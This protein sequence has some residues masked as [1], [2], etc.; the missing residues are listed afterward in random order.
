MGRLTYVCTTCEEHFTRRYSATRHNLTIHNNRVEIVS[1]LE[2]LVGRSSGRYRADHPF[3]Y[4]RRSDKRIHRYGD[5]TTVADSMGDT[6]WPGGLQQGQ[7]QYHQQSLEEQEK[8]R[9]QQALSHSIPPPAAASPYPTDQMF[10][11]QP[12]K[13]TDDE[14]KTTT[15]TLS[16]T[17]L[18]IQELKRL[19]YKYSNFSNPDGFINCVTYLS[20]N[21]DEKFL[22]EKLEQ[23]D[24]ID[25]V[26][27]GKYYTKF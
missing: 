5:V 8:Y 6:F 21:G 2:Y 4:H 16:Q 13:T 25:A 14:E 12:M 24:E 18:K 7:Y 20:I 9:Q 3:W 11:S 26:R 17:I 27:L 23:L 10:Q 15:T 19:I 1:L 22:D